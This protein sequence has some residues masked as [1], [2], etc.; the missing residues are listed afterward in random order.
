[1]NNSDEP[2]PPFDTAD[3]AK[4]DSSI[5]APFQTFGGNPIYKTFTERAALLFY[6]ITKNHCFSN[7][8]KRMAVTITVV[9]SYIN[10]RRVNISPEDMYE[11]ACWVAESRAADKEVVQSRLVDI[12][13][14][15]IKTRQ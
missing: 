7:G 11:L 1:M 9:F 13:K 8:N 12:F 14:S 10:N 2:I 6:L 15:N 5:A 4:L 3:T